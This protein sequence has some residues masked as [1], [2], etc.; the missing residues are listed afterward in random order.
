MRSGGSKG[1]GRNDRVDSPKVV[2][3]GERDAGEDSLATIKPSPYFRNVGVGVEASKV[4]VVFVLPAEHVA[5]SAARDLECVWE[6]ESVCV[7]VSV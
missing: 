1:K 3:R 4:M 7:C 6:K 2:G 5:E